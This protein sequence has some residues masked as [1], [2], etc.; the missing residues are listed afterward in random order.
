[1]AD[2]DSQSMLKYARKKRPDARNTR[3]HV[4]Y[5]AVLRALPN[6]VRNARPTFKTLQ[7]LKNESN[8]RFEP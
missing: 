2:I 6:K 1:M 3:A 8:A 4:G 7:T 5:W